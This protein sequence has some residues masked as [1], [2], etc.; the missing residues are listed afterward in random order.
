MRDRENRVQ[1]RT[2]EAVWALVPAHRPA[3]SAADV[4]AASPRSSRRHRAS[5]KRR[6]PL[7]QKEATLRHLPP[8][9]TFPC[10]FPSCCCCPAQDH[11]LAVSNQIRR[12]PLRPKNA[13]CAPLL[14]LPCPTS[15]GKAAISCSSSRCSSRCS[16]QLQL[17]LQ[18]LEAI[19]SPPYEVSP[20]GQPAS[21]SCSVRATEPH[22]PVHRIHSVNHRLR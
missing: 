5:L 12:P 13:V 21:L 11:K 19:A 8:P 14:L 10:F 2:Y 16:S 17:P 9:L 18:E 22:R 6:C 3:A 15:P 1:A 4:A 20:Y 7:K